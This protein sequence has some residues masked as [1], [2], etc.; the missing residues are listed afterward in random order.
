MHAN[1]NKRDTKDPYLDLAQH[2]GCRRRR[3]DSCGRSHLVVASRDV[4]RKARVV[5]VPRM[6]RRRGLVAA[7]G[8]HGG[9]GGARGGVLAVADV[10]AVRRRRRAPVDPLVIVVVGVAGGPPALPAFSDGRLRRPLE[11]DAATG[12]C[13][14][15]RGG[16]AAPSGVGRVGGGGV[17]RAVPQGPRRRQRQRQRQEVE[18][19]GARLWG[20]RVHHTRGRPAGS[21]RRCE[22]ASYASIAITTAVLR[23]KPRAGEWPGDAPAR[24]ACIAA[25]QWQP[26]QRQGLK[27]SWDAHADRQRGY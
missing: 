8:E 24:M 2:P 5:V 7:A 27:P 20:K 25:A 14:R 10:G 15:R 19:S 6:L 3:R 22:H 26:T 9:V 4:L 18:L 17:L 12:G 13:L 21:V 11:G 1:S 16:A 23:I